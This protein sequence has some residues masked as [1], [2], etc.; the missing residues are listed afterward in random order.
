[1]CA[2]LNYKQVIYNSVGV[3]PRMQNIV[4]MISLLM[5]KFRLYFIY[6]F[7]NYISSRTFVTSFTNIIHENLCIQKDK[8]IKL[9]FEPLLLNLINVHYD[10]FYSEILLL[11]LSDLNE[12]MSL[13]RY[14]ILDLK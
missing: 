10:I 11:D 2:I 9:Q 5:S 8:C 3:V 14:F 1:M 12:S 6:I 7:Y 13:H 4:S